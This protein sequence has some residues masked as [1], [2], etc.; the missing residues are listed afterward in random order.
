VT[1]TGTATGTYNT[2]T[3]GAITFSIAGTAV[4]SAALA[5][6]DTIDIAIG[7]LNAAAGATVFSKDSTGTK[8]TVNANGA[9][10]ITGANA[11][12]LGFAATVADVATTTYFNEATTS[13]DLTLN[14]LKERSNLANQYNDLLTQIDQLANDSK[15]NG[16]NLINSSLST[17]VLKIQFNEDNTSS[18]TVKGVDASRTGLALASVAGNPAGSFSTDTA[19]S[20]VITSLTAATGTLRG[21]ASTLGSNLTVVQNRQD[22]TKNL[23]NVLQTGAANLTDADLNEEAANSQ[24]LSTRQQLAVS[25]LS[26]ANQAQ[27]SVLQLLR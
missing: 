24:A 12:S 16:I 3:T 19:I 7:K 10:L 26:L 9:V 6:G 21:Y 1:T 15:F 14:G 13:G 20:T 22:F 25:A 4:T 11:T 18:V 8:L 23:V 5:S 27:Q 2:T 17:N